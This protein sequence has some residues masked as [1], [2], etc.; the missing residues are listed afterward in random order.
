MPN[1]PSLQDL[2][3]QLD[4]AMPAKEL[5]QKQ[6]PAQGTQRGGLLDIVAPERSYGIPLFDLVGKIANQPE[7]A[8]SLRDAAAEKQQLIQ[9][10]ASDVQGRNYE[11]AASKIIQLDPEKAS[12]LI[13]QMDK[14]NPGFAAKMKF[15]QEG[16]QTAAQTEYGANPRQLLDAKLAA[17]ASQQKAA[18]SAQEKQ[19]IVKAKPILTPGQEALD[20]EFAKEV[21][22]WDNKGG[23]AI[24]EKSLKNLDEAKKLLEGKGTTSGKVVGLLPKIARDIVAPDSGKTQDIIQ[25]VVMGSLRPI[26]GAQF[27]EEEGKRVIA[28]TFNERL[29]PK[30]NLR[31]LELLKTTLKEQ[32]A[33]KKASVEHFKK[34]GS[35]VGYEGPV[36]VSNV[37]ELQSNL[38]Q[39]AKVQLKQVNGKTYQ[40]VEGGWA[41]V[42]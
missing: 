19:N 22:D 29:S 10:I 5:D 40:K 25:D 1:N 30:E 4:K 39:K 41:L 8:Q 20:K 11:A 36:P 31:R 33:A 26:L 32:A 12:G 38:A 13:L 18:L 37:D 27:T 2:I 15:A 3:T 42:K 17:E 28:N 6:I 9:G 23:F 21:S 7:R 24:V 16:G 35:L 14:I 34:N